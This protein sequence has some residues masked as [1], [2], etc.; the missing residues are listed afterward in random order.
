MALEGQ[1]NG[2]PPEKNTKRHYTGAPQGV[3]FTLTHQDLLL[4]F[5][6]VF[7]DPRFGSI[8]RTYKKV[9]LGKL[10]KGLGGDGGL[11]QRGFRVKDSV[12]RARVS[13]QKDLGSELGGIAG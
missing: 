2:G 1:C 5:C 12:V 6:R 11:L 8:I 13:L 9:G 10:R 7:I 3:G 4:F